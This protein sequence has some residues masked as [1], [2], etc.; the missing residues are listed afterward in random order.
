MPHGHFAVGGGGPVP[1][2]GTPQPF[3]AGMPGMPQ[4]FA[5]VAGMPGTPQPFAAAAAPFGTPFQPPP[6]PQAPSSF[7]DVLASFQQK[8]G[9]APNAE[10]LAA[11]KDDHAA[12]TAMGHISYATAHSN[13]LLA[14][15]TPGGRAMAMQPSP[16]QGGMP[17][18]GAGMQFRR[19]AGGEYEYHTTSP[20]VSSP[21]AQRKSDANT[22][23]P[24]KRSARKTSVKR[25]PPPPPPVELGIIHPVFAMMVRSRDHL[26]D[27]LAIGAPS[28]ASWDFDLSKYVKVIHENK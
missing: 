1:Q 9:R 6:T 22:P 19:A 28:T 21:L 25:K 26:N 13:M 16:Y 18:H 8:L 12:A 17:F 24:R 2:L 23:E 14:T 11:L 4:P 27:V 15:M 3:A 20:S 10:E 7:V 5:A